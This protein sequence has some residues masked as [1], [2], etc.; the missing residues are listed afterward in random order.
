MNADFVS[1]WLSG[2]GRIWYEKEHMSKFYVEDLDFRDMGTGLS[3]DSFQGLL[4]MKELWVPPGSEQQVA[5]RRYL[6]GGE[7]AGA[8]EWTWTATWATDFM[9]LP[10][11]GKTTVVPGVSMLQFRDG[12]ISVEHDYWSLGTLLTQLG[13]L[14]GLPGAPSVA[15]PQ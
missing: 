14:P 15:T 2:Y 10:A 6:S 5:L 12:K 1:E 4:D 7:T 3:C 8:A 13:V 11:A 9:G